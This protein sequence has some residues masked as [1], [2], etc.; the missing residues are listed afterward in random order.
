MYLPCSPCLRKQVLDRNERAS[1]L[2]IDQKDALLKAGKAQRN[3]DIDI[4]FFM[5]NFMRIFFM[6]NFDNLLSMAWQ[7]F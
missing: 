5:R 7:R 1:L 4:L 3:T 2:T 6:R